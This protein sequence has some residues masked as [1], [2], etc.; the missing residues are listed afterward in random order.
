MI[1]SCHDLNLARR[2]A[3]HALLLDGAGHA[4]AGLVRDVLTPERAV[5][6]SAIRLP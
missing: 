6:R 4:Y 3:T 5:L 1:F 2:F